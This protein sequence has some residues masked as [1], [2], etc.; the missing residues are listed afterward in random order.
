MCTKPWSQI[1]NNCAIQNSLCTKIWQHFRTKIDNRA[2][3]IFRKWIWAKSGGRKYHNS[4]QTAH[5]DTYDQ[6]GANILRHSWKTLLKQNSKDKHMKTFPTSGTTYIWHV[7]LQVQLASSTTSL[8]A[9]NKIS[10][11]QKPPENTDP[12]TLQKQSEKSFRMNAE[13]GILRDNFT[14]NNNDFSDE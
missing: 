1:I 4:P 5:D 9:I 13:P 3:N 12:S 6:N 14:P 11:A 7:W 2:Q 10:A 8:S